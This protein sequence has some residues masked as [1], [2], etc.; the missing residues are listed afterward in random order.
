MNDVAGGD[1]VE[2]RN[3][4][5]GLDVEANF[6]DVDFMDKMNIVVVVDNCYGYSGNVVSNRN[7]SSLEMLL[8]IG[9]LW[10]A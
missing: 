6:A 3:D 4:K 5:S 9:M 10:L 8:T 7:C 1:L 2:N